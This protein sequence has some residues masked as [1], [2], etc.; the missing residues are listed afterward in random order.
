MAEEADLFVSGIVLDRKMRSETH[1]NIPLVE[2]DGIRR[3][4]GCDGVFSC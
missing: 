4:C 1:S 2:G 3:G